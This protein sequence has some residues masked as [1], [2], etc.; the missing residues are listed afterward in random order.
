MRWCRYLAEGQVRNGIVEDETILEAEG[1]PFEGPRLT[2]VSST[3]GGVR[4]LP[5]VVPGTFF[6]V[7]LNYA[8]HIRHAQEAG[9]AVAFPDRP[10]VGYRANSALIGDGEAIVRPAGCRGRFETE[11][12]LVAVIGRTLRHCSR[13]E[14]RDGVWGWTIGNDVSAREWQ[15][16][17][18]TLWRAKNSDTFKPMGPWIDTD[19][20]PLSATT[21]VRVNG[22]TRASFPT[23]AMI[24]DPFDYIEEIA[25]YITLR[26]GDVLWMGADGAVGMEPG[27][28][29]SVVI[30]GLGTLRNPVKEQ[31]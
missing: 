31:K 17:D 30:S 18:R 6:C 27:D 10:E 7:G 24:F 23:G 5:P 11:G 8:D 19:A 9:H 15:H 14:A 2:G 12:E 22:E 28:V 25:R 21:T 29:V 3:L 16:G 4:L 20:D 26:P 13:D 1:G